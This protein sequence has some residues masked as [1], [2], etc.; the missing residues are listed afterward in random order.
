M[1]TKCN[2]F[3][4]IRGSQTRGKATVE[5]HEISWKLYRFFNKVS[6]GKQQFFVSWK[7]LMEAFNMFVGLSVKIFLVAGRAT[8]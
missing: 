2:D 5:S 8:P 4:K 3:G 6:P 1:V 7:Q